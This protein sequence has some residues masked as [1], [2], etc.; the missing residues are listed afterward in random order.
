[1]SRVKSLASAIAK[2][3]VSLREAAPML[4]ISYMTARKLASSGKLR[5]LEV[6]QQRRVTIEEVER[7]IREGNY[8]EPT[9]TP[10]STV[11]E[12]PIKP[13]A[14]MHQRQAEVEL[15]PR[16][17]APFMKEAQDILNEPDE[18]SNLPPYL[19]QFQHKK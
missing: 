15:K 4:G 19:R 5:T 10:P 16:K 14:V 17:E 7:F 2:G 13:G 18:P 12:Q 8:V 11:P 9:T 1:M 6:G 3:M